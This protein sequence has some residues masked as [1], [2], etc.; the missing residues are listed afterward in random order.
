MSILGTI[1]TDVKIENI[2]DSE[3]ISFE[4]IREVDY[5]F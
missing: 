5:F 4:E 1:I 3:T 2:E